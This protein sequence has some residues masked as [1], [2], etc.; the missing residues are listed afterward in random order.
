MPKTRQ[1]IPETSSL[2]LAECALVL[3]SA[4]GAKQTVRVTSIRLRFRTE[5]WSSRESR[6]LEGRCCPQTAPLGA[7]GGG[8]SAVL[9]RTGG[10]S[11]EQ[12][13]SSWR[14]DR[15]QCTKNQGD[16]GSN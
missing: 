9:L 2:T 1:I 12:H 4:M 6:R 8:S 16:E 13:S 5:H 11:H 15:R 7:V 10:H 3:M 14:F